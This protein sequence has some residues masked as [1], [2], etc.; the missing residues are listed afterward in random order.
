MST[1]DMANMENTA[2]LKGVNS[3]QTC[4]K[5]RT[6]SGI[7]LPSDVEYV[8]LSFLF[9]YERPDMSGNSDDR[10]P[11]RR[12]NAESHL[13]KQSLGWFN[14][15]LNR[16]EANYNEKWNRECPSFPRDGEWRGWSGG[17]GIL[18]ASKGARTSVFNYLRWAITKGDLVEPIAINGSLTNWFDLDD[19]GNGFREARDVIK[20][21]DV[22][23]QAMRKAELQREVLPDEHHTFDICDDTIV[24]K[25]PGSPQHF[26]VVPWRPLL[27]LLWLASEEYEN[28]TLE[29]DSEY[30]SRNKKMALDREWTILTVSHG[31]LEEKTRK[32]LEF[33]LF[34]EQQLNWS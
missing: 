1:E 26:Q 20:M 17:G 2:R 25:Y 19:C 22:S 27:R 21:T 10:Q 14:L 12:K 23:A 29:A 15:D 16:L 31:S 32:V 11:I 28:D 18:C 24:R 34:Q 13:H 33:Y 5:F 4:I 9:N 30:I 6:D 7:E 3:Q 8:V